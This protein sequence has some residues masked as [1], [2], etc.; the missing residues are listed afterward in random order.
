[1]N[2]IRFRCEAPLLITRDALFAGIRDT[3]SW[4]T[5][6]GYGPLP[7]IRSAVYEIRTESMVGSVIRVTNTDGSTHRESI[8]T[9]EPGRKIT[10]EFSDFSR[11][12]S[13]L[14]GRFTESWSFAE[15]N[16]TT[17]VRRDM[18]LYPRTVLARPLVWL[19]ARILRRAL[20]HHLHQVACPAV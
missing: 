18:V 14:A 15:I 7:G 19:I 12:L 16:G 17:V 11:P 13:M 9:W 2:P 6:T 4:T 3:D 20:S 5:F 8:T 10:L 1:M